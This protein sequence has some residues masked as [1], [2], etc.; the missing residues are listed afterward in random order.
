MSFAPIREKV[1]VKAYVD[2][3]EYFAD[4]YEALKAAKEEVFITGWWVSP[5]MYLKRPVGGRHTKNQESRLDRILNDIASRGVRVYIAV[6]KETSYFLVLDSYYTKVSL[7]SIHKNIQV[8]RHPN[9]TIS[10]WSHHEKMIIVDQQIAFVGG[11]DLCYGR[12]DTQEHEIIDFHDDTMEKWAGFNHPGIDYYNVL[13]ADFKNVRD[14]ERDAIDRNTQPRC[15][16]HDVAVQLSG[17]PVKDL[18]RHFIQYW[19]FARVDIGSKDAHQALVAKVMYY[20]PEQTA[21][22]N[23]HSSELP[24]PADKAKLFLK[25]LKK[26]VV[27]IIDKSASKYVCCE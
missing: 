22:Y 11:L 19:N 20:T 14:C 9:Q 21:M 25:K 18:A 6:F 2:G 4:A 12:W 24:S 16:W 8:L 1:P 15:G 26:S 17:D 7:E 23:Q 13:I 3:A 5:E 27:N 10:Y